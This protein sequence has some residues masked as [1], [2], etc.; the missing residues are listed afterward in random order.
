M[1]NIRILPKLIIYFLSIGISISL[2]IGLYSYF[3]A[4]DAILKRTEEQLVSIR[5]IKKQELE[6]FMN[7]NLEDIEILATSLDLKLALDSIEKYSL[8]FDNLF[9]ESF[10]VNTPEYFKLWA[11]LG[12]YFSI[13][14][15][16]HGYYDLLI[17]DNDHGH[18]LYSVAREADLG[19]NLENG[20]YRNSELAKLRKKIIATKEI[21]VSDFH[22]YEASGGQQVLFFGAPILE[23]NEVIGVVV[24]QVSDKKIN[25][26]VNQSSGMGATGELYIIGKANDE[27]TYLRSKRRVKNGLI[28]DSKTDKIIEKCFTGSTGIEVKTGSTGEKE[29]V[30]YTPL[31]IQ[32]LNWAIFST[33]SI[34]EVM[35]PINKMGLNFLFIGFVIIL[36][37]IVFAYYISRSFS[38]PI[39]KSVLFAEEIA[40]GNLLA[41]IDINQK[42]ETGKLVVALNAMVAKISEIMAQV[43]NS[44]TQI[45]G[46]SAQL[47]DAG[48]M[49]SNSSQQLSEGASEQ[50]ASTEEVSSS[51]EE[52]AANIQQNSDNAQQTE[53]L[54]SRTNKDIDLVVKDVNSTLEAMLHIT[55]KISIIREIAERT[56]L[57]AINAAIEAARA[58]ASGKG[59]AIV[60]NEIRI[61]AEK[62]KLA[63]K[64]INSL[65]VSS[66]EI[67][68]KSTNLLAKVVPSI[69]QTTQL[70]QEISVASFEQNSGA[71]QVNNAIQQLNTITQVNASSAEELA[72]NSEELSTTASQLDIQAEVLQRTIS[73]FIQNRKVSNQIKETVKEDFNMEQK[74][75][76]ISPNETIKKDGVEIKLEDNNF[77]DDDFTHYKD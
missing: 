61:L 37:L 26:I 18:V 55:D 71:T 13:F 4:K 68:Q 75:I 15:E 64:E 62:S 39:K 76:S 36:I 5:D 66:I 11:N 52:M 29:Y 2:L 46:I 12:K 74:I 48:K 25:A 47:A 3:N 58:G 7:T 44:S 63:S 69:G 38:T 1:K 20:K 27:K 54:S 8:K 77:S 32:G 30:C 21:Q 28:G 73:F 40:K 9:L 49:T 67:A 41:T 51:M 6:S 23:K 19:T 53:Q 56:D 17:M 22:P 31:H 70:I 35:I 59:F 10:P 24:L 50:A 14:T 45:V 57:L 43:E 42:D 72:A 60:A 33:I 65:S 34:E 16:K